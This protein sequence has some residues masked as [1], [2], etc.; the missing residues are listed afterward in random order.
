MTNPL[1]VRLATVIV[2][3]AP[4]DADDVTGA[5][6][7]A[8]DASHG[9]NAV[10]NGIGSLFNSAAKRGHIVFTG[11]VRRSRAPHRKGGAIRVWAPTPAG[12]RWARS[13]LGDDS[14][15]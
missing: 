14:L 3:G 8:L 1:E 5:G 4:F 11:E 9:P 13:V 15:F 10:Q 12:V 7:V 2:A 6:A